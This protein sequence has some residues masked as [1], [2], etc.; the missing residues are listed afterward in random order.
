[1][2]LDMPALAATLMEI[3]R[4]HESLRTVFAV[5]PDHGEPVQRVL[6][7]AEGWRQPL[8]LID[9]SG[10]GSLAEGEARRLA[11]EEAARPF[12]LEKGPLLRTALV[13]LAARDHLLL[14]NM[15]HIVSD[16]WSLGVM[17]RELEALYATAREGRPSPLPELPVQYPDF[18]VWQRRWL[19][20]EVLERHLDYWRGRLAG[21]PALDLPLD[22]P[23][24]AV[25]SFRGAARQLGFG[26]ELSQGI[27]LLGRRH[28]ATPFMVLAAGLFTVLA[29]Y[30]GQPDIS[31]GSPIANRN[32][33]ETEGLIG[34]FVNTLVLRADV[35]RAESFKELLEQV[36]EVTL[37]AYAHQDMP[38]EKLVGELLPERDPSRTPFFQVSL[39]VQNA[40]LSAARLA[41]LDL[42]PVDLPGSTAKFDLTLAVGEVGGGLA[43][44]V[45][46]ATDLYDGSTALRLCRHWL[47][48][49]EAAVE[50]PAGSP[51]AL[52]LF[53]AAERHQLLVEWNDTVRAL[54]DATVV[55]LFREQA[56]RRPGA[57]ALSSREGDLS[58]AD[59]DARSDRLARRLADLGVGAEMPVGLLAERSLALLVGMLGILKAGGAYLPLDPNYPAARLAWM[60]TD[61][62]ARVLL[63]DPDKVASLPEEARPEIVVELTADPEDAAGPDPGAVLPGNLAYVLYTSGST[64]RPKAVGITHGNIVRLVREGGYAHLGPDEVHFQFAPVTFDPSTIEI[65]PA[66]THGGRLVLAPPGLLSLGDL[67]RTIEGQGVTTLQLVT[68]PFNQMVDHQLDSLRG[69]RQLL[70]GGEAMS[71]VHAERLLT[72]LPGVALTNL[73]GPTEVT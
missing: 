56:A 9:L 71:P 66:L 3:V 44:S 14:A 19:S 46:Y 8:P 54:P 5:H 41:D 52:S 50:D 16:G 33:S 39:A 1:G 32:R 49:L 21:A 26:A 30:S 6:P 59:L 40:P 45:E 47:R 31:L 53:S 20:G 60:L 65:W 69:V 17:V 13:R 28:G 57:I 68:G 63:G 7:A 23:R 61:S 12:D 42:L 27:G 2:G 25:P 55:D 24:P 38:F 36:R 11:I 18:A 64:G 22:R 15:H 67:G 58:Y 4:R 70:T 37:G 48:L 43:G 29:R 51:V 35:G 10:L 73:Y 62:G 72:G 34:F